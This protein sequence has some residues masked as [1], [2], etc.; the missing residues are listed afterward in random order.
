MEVYPLFFE[1]EYNYRLWAGEQLRT[2]LQRTYEGS[3][4]GES[5][6][7]SGVKGHENTVGNGKYTGYTLKQLIAEFKSDFLGESNFQ[8]FGLEFPLLIK[9]IATAKPLSIQVHPNDAIA[10]QRY[11]SFGKNEMWYI[12]DAQEDAELILGFSKELSKEKYQKHLSEREILDVLNVEK[13][14]SGDTFHIPTGR[15]H[16]IGKGILLAEIQQTSDITYRIYDYDRIDAKTG[17]KRQLH[18]EQALDVI[19][20]MP[21]SN[22]KTTY[23]LT[24]NKAVKLVHTPYFKTNIIQLEG[25]CSFDYRTTDSFII[26]MVVEGSCELVLNETVYPLA[27]GT[28]LVLPAKTKKLE[29]RGDTARIL[30]V[31]I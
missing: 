23:E 7:I 28:C 20:F 3:E 2:S 10:K 14:V 27:L 26:Y 5:W 30:E 12:M 13:V 9:F 15:V 4:M 6:E 29:L 18:N 11:N 8:R 22:Y 25:S 1:P 31:T 24:Q 17:E 21:H 19:D 16:A